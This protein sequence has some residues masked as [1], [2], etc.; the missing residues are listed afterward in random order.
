MAK[1]IPSPGADIACFA[2]PIRDGNVRA[3]R[4]NFRRS[5]MV[6]TPLI[7]IATYSVHI[8]V[9]IMITLRKGHLANFHLDR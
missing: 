4:T 8:L 9:T 5:N 7:F 6:G 1:T 2:L 3:D